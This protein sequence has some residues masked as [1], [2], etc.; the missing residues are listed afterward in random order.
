MNTS[1]FIWF[2]GE[3]VPWQEAKVHVMSHALHY[4]SS[5]FEGMRC[6]NSHKGPVIFRHREHIQRLY[7]SSKIYQIPISWS[8]DD[9]MQACRTIIRRNNLT[10]AYIRPVVFIGNVGMKINPDPGFTADIAIA[11]FSWLPYLGENS[12]K[13]GIDVMVSS[14]NRVPA[15]TL[16]S[17]AKAGG[18][19]LS[20]MLISN[21]AHR[22]GY[23][24]GIGLDIYGYI[25][26]GSGENL[27]EVKNNVILTPPCASS[28]LPGITRDAIIKLAVNID[29]EVQEQI[30][31]R[32]SL[33]IA[34]E[35]FMSGTAAEITPIRS[36]DGIKIGTGACG[37]I[38]KK[39]QNLFFNLFTGITKDQWNWLD[40]IN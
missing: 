1:N 19:Y 9:L 35:V 8:I 37:P 20:S 17:T 6:Y 39:L 32:E 36:V 24:E 11:A 4:G 18:N 14:W 30:L 13:E 23:Q 12:L 29:L 15:N 7:N 27:F 2:N 16:P 38:T 26:E 21:E 5:V 40:P 25:S 31:P 34:D 22:N 3:I 33:Y 10:N 28:I